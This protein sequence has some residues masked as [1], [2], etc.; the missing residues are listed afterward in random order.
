MYTIKDKQID[1]PQ[2]EQNRFRQSTNEQHKIQNSFF[3]FSFSKLL[4]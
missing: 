2:S 3:G 4:S 1:S